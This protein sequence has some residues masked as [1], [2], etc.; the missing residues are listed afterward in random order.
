MR[1][2]RMIVKVERMK[3]K[4]GRMKKGRIDNEREKG[5]I[6]EEIDKKERECRKILE[7]WIE[8]DRIE[9]MKME[10]ENIVE[11]EKGCLLMYESVEVSEMNDRI[12]SKWSMV[13]L[14][15]KE[16]GE[17]RKKRII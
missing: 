12:K 15:E 3:M 4:I 2:K 13:G 11:I 9:S 8:R 6:G 16:I 17:E 10:E 14:G 5:W 1:R 7:V